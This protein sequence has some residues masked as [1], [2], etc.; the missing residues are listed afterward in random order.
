MKIKDSGVSFVSCIIPAFNSSETIIRALESCLHTSGIEEVIVVDDGSTDDT[1]ELVAA[2]AYKASKSVRLIR[3]SNAGASG[4]RNTGIHAAKLD[5]ITFLDADDEML[6]DS[7]LSK[8]AH[9]EACRD[10]EGVGA[11]YGSFFRDYSML[12]EPFSVTYDNVARDGVGKVGRFPGGLPCYVFRRQALSAVGGF[13]TDLRMFEDFDFILR[14]IAEKVR[15]VGCQVPGF[16]RHYTPNSL[17]R[18]TSVQHRLRIERQFLDLAAR[19]RMMSKT[20]I[21]RRLLRNR[22]RQLYHFAVSR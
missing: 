15:I 7:I 9:L 18:G 19:E 6:Q 8:A 16:R 3:Q 10:S 11:V 17:T 4:A 21:T 12:P 5:W 22:I 20:E 14:L 2:A 1:A 13:R